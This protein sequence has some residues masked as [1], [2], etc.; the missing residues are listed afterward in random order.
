MISH[1]LLPSNSS[2]LQY[3][4]SFDIPLEKLSW[5]VFLQIN[6]EIW[7]INVI[8]VLN[9]FIETLKMNHSNFYLKEIN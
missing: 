3:L 1:I 6:K 2:T 7:S 8:M 9:I 4:N 5:K